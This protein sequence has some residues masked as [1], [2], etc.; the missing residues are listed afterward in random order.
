LNVTWTGTELRD[1]AQN[2]DATY[3]RHLIC[4]LSLNKK[5]LFVLV[6]IPASFDS[7]S[8]VSVA[9]GTSEGESVE[10]KVINGSIP[11]DYSNITIYFHIYVN[12]QK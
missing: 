9:L 11:S 8:W 3:A 2:K 7:V 5:D 4:L 6:D 12:V 10:L 1:T